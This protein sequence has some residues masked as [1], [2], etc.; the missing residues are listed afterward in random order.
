LMVEEKEKPVI[1]IAAFGTSHTSAQKS[2]ED[3]DTMVRERFPGHDVHWA[4]TSR[5][6]VDKL[7]K[8]GRLTMFGRELPIKTL[9]EVYADLRKEG[10]T[11][12]VLQSAHVSPGMEFHQVVMTE[13][14]GLNVKYG[15]PL[16]TSAEDIEKFV[17]VLSPQFGDATTATILCGHG[18]EGHPEF[19]A[20]L[21]QLNEIV[22]S[23]FENVFVAAVEG[24]PEFGE[25]LTRVKNSHFNR[26]KFIP[27]MLAAG[28]HIRNDVMGDDPDSW[29]KQLGLPA[30]CDTGL[31]SDPAVMEI[32]LDHLAQTLSQFW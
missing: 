2:L 21:I 14:S 29:R 12:L 31:G 17:Q 16:L 3:F 23:A 8:A 32:L 19:N 6:I 22:R 4:I 28:E 30:T 27:I 9:E 24:Q 13:T 15:Y 5:F 18:N 7:H 26:V 1:V 10:E 11:R 20:S 25:V